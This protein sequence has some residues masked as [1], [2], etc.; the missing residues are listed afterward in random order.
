R[1]PPPRDFVRTPKRERKSEP[2]RPQPVMA[3]FIRHMFFHEEHPDHGTVLVLGSGEPTGKLP[4]EPMTTGLCQ[5]TDERFNL[6]PLLVFHRTRVRSR[7]IARRARPRDP[8][9]KVSEPSIDREE[10][11]VVPGLIIGSQEWR[12]IPSLL[13]QSE[14]R[15][16]HR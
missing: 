9:A 1:E 15:Y 12:Q 2:R 14:G 3:V 10:G 13:R 6:L 5:F 4:V 8:S 16:D 7:S 11:I